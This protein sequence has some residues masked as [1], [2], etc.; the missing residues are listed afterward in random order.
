MRT[1]YTSEWYFG[2]SAQPQLHCDLLLFF[3]LSPLQH[4]TTAN[5]FRTMCLFFC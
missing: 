3:F 4:C 2:C 5:V 1:L